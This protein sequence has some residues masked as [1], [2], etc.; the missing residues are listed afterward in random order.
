MY[1]IAFFI[2]YKDFTGHWRQHSAALKWF[3]GDQENAKDPESSQPFTF[4]ND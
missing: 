4:P 2:T 1:D 3:R